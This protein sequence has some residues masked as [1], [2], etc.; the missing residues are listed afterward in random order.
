M[1]FRKI[2]AASAGR[3][4]LRYFTENTP[5]PIHPAP[6]DAAGRTL[7]EGG[8]LTAYYT[9]RDSRAAWRPDMPAILAKAIG[10]DPSQM[11]RDAEMARLFEARRADN[12]EAWSAHPRKL[13]GVDL[14]F[15]PD[16]SV[17][18]AA[19]F[20]PTPA[21]SALIWNAIDRAADRAM[22]YVA[23]EVGWA[24]RGKGGEDGA[25]PGAVGWISFRHHTARPTLQ[26]QD[27]PEGQTYL[28]DAPV[29]GDP[30]AHI[31]HFLMNIVATAD[32]RIGSLDL[33]ALTDNRIKEFGAYFQAVLADEL[34][35]LGIQVGYNENEQAVVI[36][37][38]PGD[39]GRAFSKRDRQILHKARTFAERQGLSWDDLS[40]ERK[41]DIVE[42]A[43]AE[44]RLGKMKADERRL[45]REQA[46][47]LGWKHE[48][49]VGETTHAKLSD[50]ERFEQAYRFAARHLAEEFRTA[51][52]IDHEKLG[53][54]A[55]RGLIGA[56]IAGG[57]ADIK[58]VVELIETRGI[59]IGD[60]HVS[61]VVGVFD[62][63]LRVSNTR[64]IRIEE[65]L[66]SLA[67]ATARDRSGALAS[68]DLR[69]AMDRSKVRFSADQ[70]AAI[71]AL[72]Q[73]GRLTLLTGAAGVGKTTILEPVV[74]AWKAD[75]R[76]DAKGRE[77][78]GTAL[79]WRQAD[80]L[81]DAGID[82][83]Y[84]LSPLLA[85]IDRGDITV[86]RNTVLVIDEVSQVGPRP[87]LKL[88]E[89]QARTGTTI[90]MLGDREQAQAIE[91]GDSIELLRRALPPEALP[92]LLTTVRQATRRGREIA[93]LFREGNGSD[94]LEMKREDGHARLLGGDRDQV[95]GQI[96][97]LYIERRDILLASGSKRGIT[98]SAPTN[99]DAA[100]ISKAIRARLKERGE[101]AAA[102]TFHKAIDQNGREF[103]LALATGDRV[104]LFRRT[105]GS[106]GDKEHQ[107]GNNGDVV[108]ILSQSDCGLRVRTAKGEIA[109]IDWR[110]LADKETGRLLLGLGHALTIDAAQGL[111]SDEHI[112]A[113]PRGT[114]GVTGF[115]SYV[116]ESRARGTTWT[117]ISEGALHEAERHRQAVGDATP[118]T[119][120][121]LWARAAADM[122]EKPYK[123]LGIDLLNATRHD[124][125]RAIDA[126]IGAHHAMEK[127][128]LADRDWGVKAS[129]RVRAI[130]VNEQ[131]GR[132]LP[133]LDAAIQE[134]G[135]ILGETLRAREVQQH[136]RAL[137]AEAEM[138]R[139]RL[140]D[141]APVPSRSMS[142]GP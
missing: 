96:A 2:A 100:D 92:V 15:S 132:H 135:R 8:R 9:G 84:A 126:F 52:V 133:S 17:T 51:A 31:H 36:E 26:V 29:A 122:S 10:I 64:Q 89:L 23:Q 25:D 85:M 43:S 136:L 104:R 116:A 56:G 121:T 13:S 44:G 102:E 97:D 127:A 73:G 98:I 142:P 69:Q 93:A 28:F 103:D 79:A 39:I 30:H 49:V 81:R 90:K 38:V 112:N 80:A 83:A 48:S 115:T 105:W 35:R 141:A 77:V 42:E 55:A 5:E 109:D 60:E 129:R 62:D 40:A 47:A 124:R 67:H 117:L 33:R 21:E 95:V 120:N 34:R 50:E 91:A 46:D 107:V 58:R 53:L 86:S 70:K 139:L 137:R 99:E 94:A 134:N 72:G 24:R 32:G 59:R 37:S 3:L 110:R 71:F 119:Q 113:L 111:T 106:V 16:K 19:E 123:A 74:A 63:K 78:I 45:W 114:S 12:G 140:S 118:I 131:L 54:H 14:V 41:L 88:L 68:S 87:L 61:L 1:N 4:L 7:E 101:I 108:E 76:F 66:Q 130:V 128:T 82:R 57:P 11:P 18:L 138:A 75:T 6:V 27:G 22:R 20:A 125:E 65:R